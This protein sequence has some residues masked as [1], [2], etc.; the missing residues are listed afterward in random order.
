MSCRITQTIMF[1]ALGGWFLASPLDSFGQAS[2]GG[3]A[4]SA[5]AGANASGGAA[6]GGAAGNV[7]AG[8]AGGVG[9]NLGVTRRKR[10]HTRC[11]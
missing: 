3:A 5:S 4:G 11:N 8:A 1:A 2:G 6:A 10:E 9:T 7:Q